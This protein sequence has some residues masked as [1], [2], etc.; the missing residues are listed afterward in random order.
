[1]NPKKPSG[2]Q[3]IRKTN[4]LFKPGDLQRDYHV[5]GILRERGEKR[6]KKKVSFN[7]DVEV[8][9]V[10]SYKVYN[11]DMGKQAR[12]KYKREEAANADCSLI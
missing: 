6:K 10:E 3:L 12:M 9:N 1:M 5:K 4:P 7:G 11:V 2:A 8:Y